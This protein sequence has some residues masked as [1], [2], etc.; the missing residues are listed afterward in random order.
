MG[1]VPMGTNDRRPS[2]DQ[3]HALWRYNTAATLLSKVAVRSDLTFDLI[4]QTA[5]IAGKARTRLRRLPSSKIGHSG[6]GPGTLQRDV[7]QAGRND[8]VTDSDC[9]KIVHNL[10]VSV[11][12][13]KKGLD[14]DVQATLVE[15]DQ[16][17]LMHLNTNFKW[18]IAQTGSDMNNQEAER[19][20]NIMIEHARRLW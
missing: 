1:C 9:V 15:V 3:K 12:N 16:S 11:E 17:S 7:G 2:P 4:V 8:V 20:L 10:R 18:L 5:E 14:F 19:V 13:E 6:K